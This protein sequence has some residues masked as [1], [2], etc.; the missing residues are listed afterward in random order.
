MGHE[1]PVLQSGKGSQTRT[2]SVLLG[3]DADL[4]KRALNEALALAGP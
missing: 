1:S 3:S 2:Q 4:K